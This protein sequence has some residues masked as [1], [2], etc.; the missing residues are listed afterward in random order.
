ML[1]REVAEQRRVEG[2]V[3]VEDVEGGLRPELIDR[4]GFRRDEGRVGGENERKIVDLGDRCR[5]SRRVR[6]G[7]NGILV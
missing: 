4:R 5:S 2:D 7:S 3:T 6:A 1:F